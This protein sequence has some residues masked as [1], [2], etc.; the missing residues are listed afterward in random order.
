MFEI[1]NKML[2]IPHSSA[3]SIDI[4]NKMLNFLLTYMLV[5]FFNLL[6]PCPL[7]FSGQ[8]LDLTPEIIRE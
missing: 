1:I 4:T 6:V 5:I 8:V 2:G 7:N 3:Y